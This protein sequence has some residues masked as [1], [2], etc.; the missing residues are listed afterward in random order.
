MPRQPDLTIQEV[1]ASHLRD[2]FRILL[3]IERDPYERRQLEAE[4]EALNTRIAY[5][6]NPSTN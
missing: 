4:I 3:K 5:L 1:E 6:R 2:H